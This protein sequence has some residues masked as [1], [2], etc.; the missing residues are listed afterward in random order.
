MDSV[1]FEMPEPEELLDD[2]LLNVSSRAPL[3]TQTPETTLAVILN[4]YEE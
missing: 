3:A 1:V 4:L 2:W